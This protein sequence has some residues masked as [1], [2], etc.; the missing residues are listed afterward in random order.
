MRRAEIT[1]IGPE[2]NNGVRSPMPL[3]RPGF[4]RRAAVT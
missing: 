3:R 1:G 4:R 2:T